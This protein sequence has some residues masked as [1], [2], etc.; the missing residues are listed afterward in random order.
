MLS[1]SLCS[2][3]CR[4]GGLIA[5]AV[6]KSSYQVRGL[7]SIPRT[8]QAVQPQKNQDNRDQNYDVIYKFPYIVFARSVCRLKIYQTAITTLAVPCA[9]YLAHVGSVELDTFI[10]IVLTNGLA[11]LMLYVM[12]EIFRRIIG[13]ISYNPE[14]GV[15]KISHLTFW[16]QRRDIFVPH[17]DIVPIADTSDN[18]NDIYIRF[19]RY[20]QP[21]FSL[22]MCLRFGGIVDFQKFYQVFGEL[23]IKGNEKA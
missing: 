20:S 11:I 23:Q 9:G 22:F 12:G 10:S 17:S 14:T 16:G 15:V 13:H 19:L 18:P 3:L 6:S 5:G 7:L 8:L 4:R 2:H 1:T 21:K